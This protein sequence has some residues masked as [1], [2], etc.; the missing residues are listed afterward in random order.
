MEDIEAGLKALLDLDPRLIPIRDHAGQLPLRRNLPGFESLASIIVGQQVSIASAAAI[1]A[2]FK[3][4]ID[5]ITPE[6]YLEQGAEVWKLTG[7]SRPKQ[8]TFQHVSEALVDGRLDLPSLTLLPVNDAMSQL[9]AIHGIGPWTAEVYLLFA[10]GHADIFPAGD[11]ALQEAVA[12]G[13]GL[14]IRP[15]VKEL[16]TIAKDWAPH[17]GIAARLFWAYYAALRGKEAAP[18]VPNV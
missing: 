9:T 14:N 1:W 7:L 2:R 3:Q 13:L 12:R 10:E 11:V 16:S 17:R 4:Y 8:K 6:N 5:P 18:V 15:N